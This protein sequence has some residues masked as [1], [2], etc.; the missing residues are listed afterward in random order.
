MR[1]SGYTLIEL[2]ITV[3]ILSIIISVV[4]PGARSFINHSLLS[5]EINELSSLSRLARFKAM[6][7]QSDVILCPTKDYSQCITNWTYAKMAFVDLDG[8]GARS[9]DETMIG[10]TEILH[11]SVSVQAP[12]SS[13][14]FDARGGANV[15]ATLTFCDNTEKAETAV[16][17]I[18]NGYG[19]IAIAKDSNDDNI[20]EDH[21]GNSLSCTI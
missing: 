15:T 1:N 10:S 4:A 9:S 7:E 19:K 5:K 3:A 18:I 21:S 13:I 17:L 6:D 11:S 8:N 12:S 2:M 16:G 20:K 14:I